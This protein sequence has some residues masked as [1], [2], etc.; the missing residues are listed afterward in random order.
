MLT[1]L[2]TFI[3]L[4][5]NCPEGGVL[6]PDQIAWLESELRNAPTGMALILAV[7]HPLYSAYGAHPGSQKL[8]TVIDT[9]CRAANRVPDLVLSGHVHDYQRFTGTLADQNVQCIVAGAGGYNLKLHL[10][11]KIFHN[12]K[13]PIAMKGSG[14]ILEK[15]NDAQHGYLRLQITKKTILC[16]YFAVPEPGVTAKLPLKHFDSVTITIR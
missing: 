10:L 15:F 5:S 1:P 14:A 6:K 7:H 9:A 3:G 11:S 16:E 13:L 12:T 4:Y 8:Y 2:A